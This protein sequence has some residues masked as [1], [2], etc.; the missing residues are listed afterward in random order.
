M[1]QMFFNN[2]YM[3]KILSSWIPL[4]FPLWHGFPLFWQQSYQ[5]FALGSVKMLSVKGAKNQPRVGF[6]VHWILQLQSNLDTIQSGF[7]VHFLW[8]ALPHPYLCVNFLPDSLPSWLLDACQQQL[9]LHGASFSRRGRLLLI[10]CWER[11]NT[12][13][14][15]NWPPLN[16]SLKPRECHGLISLGWIN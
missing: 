5:N 6:K 7:W 1:R 10:N 15:I 11:E 12:E 4:N 13:I 16:Q 3:V 14:Y 8:L 2:S 9:V